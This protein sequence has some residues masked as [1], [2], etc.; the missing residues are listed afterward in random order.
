MAQGARAGL[1]WAL[2]GLLA[3]SACAAP[4][5]SPNAPAPNAPT[6]PPPASAASQALVAYYAGLDAGLRGRGL[7]RTDNGRIDAPY[8]ARRLAET[9]I[10][11]ALYDE[12]TDTPQGYVAQERVSQLRKWVVPVRVGL[13]FGA[14]VPPDKVARERA[15]VGAYL[16][17]L[18][19]VTGHPIRL[20]DAGANFF[21]YYVNEDERLALAPEIA[22]VMP[23][24][25]PNEIAAFTRM[26][27]STYCQVSVVAGAGSGIYT[28]AFALIR[29]EH[30]DLMSLACLHEEVAQGLG[31]PNDSPA[32]A[33]RSSTTI[34]SSP[35]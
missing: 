12:F 30:T 2:A 28:R 10:R 13:R 20:S 19:A 1:G 3:L 23:G 17:R 7:L 14:S 15:R 31:L 26:S 25:A 18:S 11:I 29:A 4:V 32:P 24:F 6:V 22:R 5:P 21:L 16:A 33:P 8:D 34:R 27:P 9:F 35:C